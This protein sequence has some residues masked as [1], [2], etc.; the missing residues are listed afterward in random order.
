MPTTDANANAGVPPEVAPADTPMDSVPT[1]VGPGLSP[2]G[3]CTTAAEMSAVVGAMIVERF[4]IDST[5]QETLLN[6]LETFFTKAGVTNDHIFGFMSDPTSWPD[7]NRSGLNQSALKSVTRPVILLLSE[8]AGNV[9]FML[10]KNL[11][12]KAG[13]KYDDFN[14]WVTSNM[15]T[16][17][18]ITGS[19][20]QSTLSNDEH[21]LPSFKVPTF[22]GDLIAGDKY[23]DDVVISFTN[24]AMEKY[25][26]D[27]AWCTKNIEWSG[28]FASRIRESIKHNDILGFI[29]TQ[30]ESQKNCAK[31]WD[32]VTAH[33]TSSDLTMARAMA[34]WNTLFS[35]K[36]ED[37]D[38]F[39]HFYSKAKSMVFKLK[40]DNSTAIKDDI[41]LR[42][43]FAKAIEA[44]ELQTNVKK[45]VTDR[46]GTY[47]T[48]LELI[49]KDFRAQET[50]DALRDNPSTHHSSRRSRTE[51]HSDEKKKRIKTEEGTQMTRPKFPDNENQL[52]PSTYYTQFK[53][54]YEHMIVPA[55]ERTENQ[56]A[57]LRTFQFDFR[58][59]YQKR[60]GGGFHPG[61][62]SDNGRSSGA[63]RDSDN[64]ERPNM[65][66][67]GRSGDYRVGNGR[68]S[69]NNSSY[70]GRNQGTRHGRRVDFDASYDDS[71]DDHHDEY[72]DFL[73]WRETR[74]R[75]LR[76]GRASGDEGDR[77]A[78][79]PRREQ[80]F[81]SAP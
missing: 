74:S 20:S 47:D 77:E 18:K 8:L 64:G 46:A 56:K 52:L 42:A 61:S 15:P 53:Q 14:K 25:L 1:T 51:D 30:E 11:Y 71:K 3:V 60:Y 49:H 10:S 13:V 48:I 44:P 34:H 36:C 67:S 23:I 81:R 63:K 38:T 27:S 29:A 78:S 12:L 66:Y 31:L 39:L 54:W 22:K 69:S 41:F 4:G 76:R 75:S 65:R 35:L 73:E 43:Y 68:N 37:R 33:L 50:N 70:D 55:D 62:T 9:H 80:F 7:P 16:P 59:P 26:T 72:A 40:R 57:W 21:K 5:A 79:R 17:K 28:A 58:T 24:V 32:T 45:L 19:Q 6:Q 2:T